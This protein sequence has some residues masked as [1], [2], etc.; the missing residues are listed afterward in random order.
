M[1]LFFEPY[2]QGTVFFGVLNFWVA[3]VTT[4]FNVQVIVD[5]SA[6]TFTISTPNGMFE[7]SLVTGAWSEFRASFDLDLDTVSVSYD[8]T[9]L[10]A[11]D[12]RC[13]THPNMCGLLRFD[14]RRRDVR[15][16]RCINTPDSIPSG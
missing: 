3:R 15:A 14:R 16:T 12:P 9:L 6:G 10:D 4:E 1:Q 13:G 5:Q 11:Y 2:G 8:G 7:E